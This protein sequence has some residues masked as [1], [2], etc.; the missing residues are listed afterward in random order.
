MDYAEAI[1]KLQTNKRK[2]NYLVI[3]LSYD[4]KIVLPHKDGIA[5]LATLDSAEQLNELYGV[6]PSITSL[7]RDK[8]TVTQMS[9]EEYEC[10]KVAT[11]L[12]VTPDEVKEQLQKTI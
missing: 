10:F 12:G 8:V 2:E 1:E 6:K 9:H 4:T 3:V 11:L 7:A 5:L